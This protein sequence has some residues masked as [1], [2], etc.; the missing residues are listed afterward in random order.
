MTDTTD[1][2]EQGPAKGRKMQRKEQK[3]QNE[4]EPAPIPRKQVKVIENQN[5]ELYLKELWTE[6]DKSTDKLFFIK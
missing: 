4:T 5:T 3:Q 1:G 6:I 2:T